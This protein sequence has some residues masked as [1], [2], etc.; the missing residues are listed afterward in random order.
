MTNWSAKLAAAAAAAIV[1]TGA[2]APV[3][4]P[5]AQERAKSSAESV[6]AHQTYTWSAELVEFDAASNSVTVRALLVS[7][8]ESP[9]LSKLNAGER[10]MLTWSGITM[11]AGVRAVERGDSSS[12]DRMTM[13][14]EFV[15]SELDGRYVTFKVPVPADSAASLAKLQPGAYV[16]AT[17][18]MRA[19]NAA[20]AV[21][22]IRPYNDVS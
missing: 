5:A 14:I 20:E 3:M 11:A 2:L 13:P 19:K 15:A 18:P 8:P 21:V 1:V 7:N 4:E 9:D 16:T 17:S 12:F 22:A 10:A 6:E